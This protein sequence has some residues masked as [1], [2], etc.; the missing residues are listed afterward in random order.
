M[1]NFDSSFR[2]MQQKGWAHCG[3]LFPSEIHSLFVTVQYNYLLNIYTVYLCS[4][5]KLIQ[6]KYIL[7][8]TFSHKRPFNLDSFIIFLYN[9]FFKNLLIYLTV[10][11]FPLSLFLPLILCFSS[12]SILAPFYHG[13]FILIL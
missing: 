3:F 12:F 13:T 4:K 6:T 2:L 1:V 9:A 10:L 5:P 7:L 11:I 8:P